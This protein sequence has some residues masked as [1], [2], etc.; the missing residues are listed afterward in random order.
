MLRWGT[1]AGAISV[2]LQMLTNG[3]E[4]DGLYRG[5]IMSSG[6]PSPTKDITDQQSYYNIVVENAGCA[7]ASDTL[8][9]LRHV[10]ADTL[11]AAAATLP[12]L[13]DYQVCGM[14]K[15]MQKSF[16]PLMFLAHVQGLA[17]PWAPHADGTFL[18][19]PPQHLVRSGSVADVPFITSTLVPV[20]YVGDRLFVA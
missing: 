15:F 6:S 5:A 17:T 2:S 12:N 8:E 11:L 16:R 19:A 9:C 18:T 14:A 10:P 1:S 7:N 20:L 3:G 4:S 13:L